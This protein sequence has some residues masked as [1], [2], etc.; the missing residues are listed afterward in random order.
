ME[1]DLYAPP[2]RTVAKRRLD[3]VDDAVFMNSL[4]TAV[5]TN[6]KVNIEPWT[7]PDFKRPTRTDEIRSK[8]QMLHDVRMEAAKEST[9]TQ[10]LV[11]DTLGNAIVHSQT[12]DTVPQ[13]QSLVKPKTLDDYLKKKR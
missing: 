13:F 3:V 2:K 4:A 6:E 1:E 7:L 10:V 9:N 5:P 11:T 12:E 8:N